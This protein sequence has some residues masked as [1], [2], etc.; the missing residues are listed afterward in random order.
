MFWCQK[1][2]ANTWKDSSKFCIYHL[3]CAKINGA[4]SEAEHWAEQGRARAGVS[5]QRS[6]GSPQVQKSFCT[7]HPSPHFVCPAASHLLSQL[8]PSSS[9]LSYGCYDSVRVK[10]AESNF[11][12]CLDDWNPRVRSFPPSFLGGCWNPFLGFFPI[13][14]CW[15]WTERWSFFPPNHTKASFS[16][17][18]SLQTSHIPSQSNLE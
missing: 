12:F 8:L 16:D 1:A 17:L 7:G 2:V 9:C 5:S 6:P 18:L 3:K 14:V 10:M 15:G 13:P 11:H 4:A